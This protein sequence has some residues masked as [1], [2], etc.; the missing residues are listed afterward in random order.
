MTYG[1]QNLNFDRFF[2]DVTPTVTTSVILVQKIQIY[3][4]LERGNSQKSIGHLNFIFDTC[5]IANVTSENDGYYTG[6]T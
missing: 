6:T 1:S 5:N 4:F 2:T 3:T